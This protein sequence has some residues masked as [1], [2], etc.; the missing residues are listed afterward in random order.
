MITFLDPSGTMD[1]RAMDVLPIGG[2]AVLPDH[3]R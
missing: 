3:I 2:I 1:D